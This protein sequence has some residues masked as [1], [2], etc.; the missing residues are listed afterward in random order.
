MKSRIIYT[1]IWQDD[2]FDQLTIEEKVFSLYL[3]TNDHVGLTRI[4]KLNTKSIVSELGID[5]PMIDQLKAT[6]QERG[7]F[8]FYERWVYV[9]NEYSYCDYFGGKTAL[10]KD[11]EIGEL[12]LE[13]LNIIAQ[14]LPNDTTIVGYINHKSEIINDKSELINH[15]SE[16]IKHKTER[17]TELKE[18]AHDLAESKTMGDKR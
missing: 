16:N 1:S 15:K 13:V 6:L 8:Y 4:Y 7:L 14:R 3:L 18:K 2:V 5:C 12:P 10:A 9:T 11:K 17:M